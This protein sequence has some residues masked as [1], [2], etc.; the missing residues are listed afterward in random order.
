MARHRPRRGPGYMCKGRRGYKWLT[1]LV[2]LNGNGV[3]SGD[4]ALAS[5]RGAAGI[6]YNIVAANTR[7]R[8]VGSRKTNTLR[9]VNRVLA[10]EG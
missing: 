6:A 5:S 7:H 9:T 1:Y 10:Q 2:H 4:W 3:T 8:V